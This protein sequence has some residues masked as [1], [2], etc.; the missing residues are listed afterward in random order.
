MDP[1]W[2]R[3]QWFLGGLGVSGSYMAV[4]KITNSAVS[5]NFQVNAF[6]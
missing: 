6:G 1:I 4:W 5:Y 2:I 3:C